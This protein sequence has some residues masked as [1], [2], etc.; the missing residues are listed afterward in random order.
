MAGPARRKMSIVTVADDVSDLLSWAAAHGGVAV[1]KESQSPGVV[2]LNLDKA[3]AARA[4]L[5]FPR[6]LRS[7]LAS[8]SNCHDAVLK[9]N[10]IEAPAVEFTAPKITEDGC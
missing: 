7:E 10:V 5:I 3:I 8:V 9:L 4:F 1:D 2:E 6:I